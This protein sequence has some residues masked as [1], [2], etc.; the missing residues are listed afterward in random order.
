MFCVRSSSPSRLTA[1]VFLKR[2]M[3]LHVFI[4]I[5]AKS[6]C[7]VK[8]LEGGKVDLLFE[9]QSFLLF[10][11]QK[12]NSNCPYS[13]RNG[14]LCEPPILTLFEVTVARSNRFKSDFVFFLN[15]RCCCSFFKSGPSSSSSSSWSSSSSPKKK[16]TAAD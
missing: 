6:L 1:R 9:A 7:V 3:F 4:Q 2:T 11:L 10:L 16:C 14:P 8:Q 12:R 5:L 15:T 13:V